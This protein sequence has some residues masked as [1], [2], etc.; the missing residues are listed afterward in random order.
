MSI[1]RKMLMGIGADSYADSDA[2]AD[3][4]TNADTDA[5]IHADA[6]AYEDTNKLMKTQTSLQTQL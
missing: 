1:Q 4:A 3:V 2:D 6:D 5:G